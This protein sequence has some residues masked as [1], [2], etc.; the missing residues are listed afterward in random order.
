MQLLCAAAP[1]RLIW[2]LIDA[3]FVIALLVH[4]LLGCRSSQSFICSIFQDV[5]RYGKTKSVVQR[6]AWVYYLD[7]PKRWFT[8]FYLVSLFW[9]GILLWFL[10]QKTLFGVDFPD[11]IRLLHHFL[12]VDSKEHILGGEFSTILSL[13]LLWL[14]SLRRLMECLF[15]SVFSSGVINLVQYCFGLG[16]YLLVGLTILGQSPLNNRTVSVADLLMQARW[17]HAIGVM[18]YIWASLHQYRCHV[19]LANL[20]KSKSGKILNLKHAVPCGDWFERVSCPHYFAELL[21]Y[22]SI[23][24]VLGLWNTTWW[25][26]VIY[27]LFNQALA[28]VLSHEFY[29]EKFDNYPVERKAF[30][31]FIF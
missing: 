5:I 10:L 23:A 12:N 28:A 3:A 19:I 17:Y 27:V 26:V 25:L 9:N 21:I 29:H 4:L 1:V 30:I 14:L 22:I 16:Y 20:R 6:P 8:H 13:A 2:V 18:L 31:P 11:C 15:V 7:V 24:I